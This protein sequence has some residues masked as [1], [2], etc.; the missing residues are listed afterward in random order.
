MSDIAQRWEAGQVPTGTALQEIEAL[1]TEIQNDVLA[2]A[3]KLQDL[4]DTCAALEA[5]HEQALK[6][7]DSRIEGIA[8]D[9]DTK[10]ENMR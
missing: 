8:K 5:K 7:I 10:D 4:I 6:D 2:L 3:Q 1:H 9:V